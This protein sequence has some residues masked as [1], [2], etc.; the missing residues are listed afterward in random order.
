LNQLG[1]QGCDNVNKLE[2][3]KISMANVLLMTATINP[4]KGLPSLAR[5]DPD[6]RRADYIEALKFYLH[7]LGRCFDRIVFAE[8]SNA[9]LSDLRA[10]VL[11]HSMSNRVEFVSFYGLDFPPEYGRGFGEFK[12]VDYAV[13][14][15]PSLKQLETVVWKVT[16]RYVLLNMEAMVASY[17]GADIYCHM[18]DYPHRLC[19]LAFLAWTQ[20]GYKRLIQGIAPML[21]NDQKPTVSEEVHFRKLID[22]SKK[23]L[24][25]TPRLKIV[26]IIEGIRGWDNSRYSNRN[27]PKILMRRAANVLIPWFWI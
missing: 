20:N 23:Q 3:G 14:Q 1:A 16:G 27:S 25:I 17:P 11:D 18:R 4:L 19:E 13:S 24:L 10:L 7:L 6:L 2:W 21:R 8:N 22:K 15:S 26:P 12:M 9:D 5:I